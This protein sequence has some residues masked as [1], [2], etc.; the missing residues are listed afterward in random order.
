MAG[1]SRERAKQFCARFGR[2]LPILLVR[3]AGACPPS[4]SIA[5]ADA[6]SIDACGALP[7]G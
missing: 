3:M 7:R 4:L 6:G 5:V 2:D 1:S